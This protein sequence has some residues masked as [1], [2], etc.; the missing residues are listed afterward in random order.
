M[1]PEAPGAADESRNPP[2]AKDP[3]CGMTVSVATAKHRAELS[4]RSYYFCC[5]GC[6]EKFLA[7]PGKFGA[8]AGAH[9]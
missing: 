1:N 6:R 5:A 2:G 3:V 4:G 8:A 9:G 7:S